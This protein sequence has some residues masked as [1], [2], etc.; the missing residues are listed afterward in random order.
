MQAICSEE[1][2]TR[3]DAFMRRWLG[4]FQTT[5]YQSLSFIIIIIT[6]ITSIINHYHFLSLLSVQ[7]L[8]YFQ[9]VVCYW[10]SQGG[11]RKILQYSTE[12]S[13]ILPYSDI[14]QKYYRRFASFF[15]TTFLEKCFQHP[16]TFLSQ[17]FFKIEFSNQ[18][19]KTR[20]LLPQ[21]L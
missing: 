1:Q 19:L 11:V 12:Y 13:E 20:L 14:L 10:G 15:Y 3:E 21:R 4:V 18:T 6:F 5:H 7:V 2:V 17:A 16:S 8:G 9:Q